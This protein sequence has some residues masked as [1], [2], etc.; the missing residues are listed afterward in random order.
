MLLLLLLWHGN[1]SIKQ[2]IDDRAIHEQ[3]GVCLH[4][5]GAHPH[6][7]AISGG[8]WQLLIEP[9]RVVERT[10]GA[11]GATPSP[12]PQGVVGIESW[13]K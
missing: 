13:I 11:V 6:L 10:T 4:Y 9:W 3:M 1:N 5:P 8:L 2:K 12:I 7:Y